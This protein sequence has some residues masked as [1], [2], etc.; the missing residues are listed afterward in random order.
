MFGESQG[1][2]VGIIIYMKAW[3]LFKPKDFN[4][5]MMSKIMVSD[6]WSMPGV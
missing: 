2:F 3:E 5:A 6:S 1:P 4:Y